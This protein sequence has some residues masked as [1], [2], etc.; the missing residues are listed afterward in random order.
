MHDRLNS[1]SVPVIAATGL[2]TFWNRNSDIFEALLWT[3]GFLFAQGCVLLVLLAVLLVTSYGLKLPPQDDL[4]SWVLESNLDRSFL[5]VGVPVLGALFL[6][7]PAIRLREGREFR[8]RIGWRLP[9]S[10]ETVYSLAMVV[11]VALI[12][13]VI[14]DVL[15]SWWCGERVIWPF[16]VALR[17]SSLDHL[18][19]T[20]QGVPYPVLVVALAL[21][22]AVVEELV[23]R[24]ML[25]RR[26][27]ERFGAPWGI[28]I[29]SGLFAAVHGSPPHAIATI[30]I[31][32]LLHV[33]YL[34]TGTIAI[35]ILVH[36]GNNLLAVS[37]VH[38]KLGPETPVSAMFMGSLCG[39]LGLMLFLLHHRT[40]QHRWQL[41][42]I[43]MKAN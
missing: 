30:P 38:F 9:T 43:T 41:G 29:A 5:L 20:F 2:R 16:A 42:P 25:G 8:Q 23:F 13:N 7:I 15:N 26:L 21:A 22:P 37:L 35:P 40:R 32:V 10:E 1:R 27:V 12:G 24:G 33:L 6:I 34:Q 19:N 39:Y 4:L 31:A 14:Y 17:E 18:Y 11:P 28:C 3:F 36:F